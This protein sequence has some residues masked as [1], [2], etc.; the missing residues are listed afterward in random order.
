MTKT[1]RVHEIGEK[2]VILTKN[3]LATIRTSELE[4]AL[5]HGARVAAVTVSR[6][7]ANPPWVHELAEAEYY[8]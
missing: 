7:G 8:D 4:E 1:V 2:V 3:A 6:S 5:E